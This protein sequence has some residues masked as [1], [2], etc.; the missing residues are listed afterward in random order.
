MKIV[1]WLN[2]L[3]KQTH[4]CF[5]DLEDVL[6]IQV[7]K[8]LSTA[9]RLLVLNIFCFVGGSSL[10]LCFLFKMVGMQY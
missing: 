6:C 3:V 1:Q 4:Y 7:F 10:L 2:I 8:F 5:S 9:L